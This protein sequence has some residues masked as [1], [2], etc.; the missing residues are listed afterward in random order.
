MNGR[1]EE[2]TNYSQK[3]GSTNIL[4]IFMKPNDILT[5][6]SFCERKHI[7]MFYCI[8]VLTKQLL[9]FLLQETLDSLAY[10]HSFDDN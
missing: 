4:Y 7:L 1:E 8:G 5:T 9:A 3:N 2:E 10:I 6:K